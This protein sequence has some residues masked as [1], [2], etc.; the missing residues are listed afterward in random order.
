M[1]AFDTSDILTTGLTVQGKTILSGNSTNEILSISGSTGEIMSINDT[2]SATLVSIGTIGG[3]P[4]FQV[5]TGNS[6][7]FGDFTAPQLGT[8]TLTTVTS[9]QNIYSIP[10]ATYTGAFYDYTVSSTTGV[11]AGTVIAIWSGT[12]VE[13]TELSTNS[14]GTTTA[15]TFSISISSGNAILS[16]TATSGTWTV[17]TMIRTI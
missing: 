16:A 14:I 3:S 17:K 2:S 15:L 10:T 12:T 8:T 11:R 1:A 9:T 6:I 4:I 13:Y 5:F 7:S